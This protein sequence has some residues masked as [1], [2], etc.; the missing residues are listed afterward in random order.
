MGRL[1]VEEPINPRLPLEDDAKKVA[2]GAKSRIGTEINQDKF[3][4]YDC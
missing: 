1:W 3:L 2:A 4:F